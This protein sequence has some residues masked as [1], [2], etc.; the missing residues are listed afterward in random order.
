V[1]RALH[2]IVEQ[3]PDTFSKP[4]ERMAGALNVEK[5]L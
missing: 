5:I 2:I 4:P 1:E 3:S